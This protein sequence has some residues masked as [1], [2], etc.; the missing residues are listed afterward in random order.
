MKIKCNYEF[1]RCKESVELESLSQHITRCEYRFC[2][3]CG[4]E[5]NGPTDEHNCIEVLKNMN[6]EWKVKYEKSVQTIKESDDRLEKEIKEKKKWK[7]NYK[8]ESKLVNK[9]SKENEKQKFEKEKKELQSEI[10]NLQN[11]LQKMSDK[12][13]NMRLLVEK[14][15]ECCKCLTSM[16]SSESEQLDQSLIV[17]DD[18]VNV[19]LWDLLKCIL[20]GEVDNHLIGVYNRTIDCNRREVFDNGTNRMADIVEQLSRSTFFNLVYNHCHYI[21]INELNISANRRFSVAQ[22]IS[23][24]KEVLIPEAIV[25]AI[26]II[27]DCD[28]IR[29]E[30]LFNNMK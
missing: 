3:T 7:K 19:N 8:E 6:N 4:F 10:C 2:K 24:I 14:H 15:S 21:C 9:Y 22:R 5:R 17:I 13:K 23:F 20:L 29:A 18:K 16:S 11:K 28:S 26:A 27:H 12:D 30:E 1:N 25:K